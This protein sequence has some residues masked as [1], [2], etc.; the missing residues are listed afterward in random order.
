[1]AIKGKSKPK[2]KRSVTPGPRPVYVPV[3]RPLVQRRGVQIGVLA[4]VLVVAAGAIAYGVVRERNANHAKEQTRIEK[5]IMNTYS[6]KVQTAISSVGSPDPGGEAFGLLPDLK[7]NIDDLR[8]GKAK[9]GAVAT[10][11]KGL[12]DAASAAAAA[13]G[14]IDTAGIIRPKGVEDAAFVRDLI[15]ATFKMHDGLQMEAIAATLLQQAAT[16]P[17]TERS[18]LLDDADQARTTAES[19]FA[20]GYSDWLNAQTTA[21]TFQ[22]TPLPAGS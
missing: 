14:K 10:T 17:A 3:K 21:G 7:A 2:A 1:M 11:A 6:P 22:P 9:P 16:A 18:A 20:S 13:L 5:D 15:N 19:V 12:H 8:S 4:V